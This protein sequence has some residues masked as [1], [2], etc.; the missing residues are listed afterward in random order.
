MKNNTAALTYSNP[1]MEAIIPDWPSG[2][3]L[4][5]ATFRIEVNSQGERATRTTVFWFV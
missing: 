4:M 2:S 1:R 3:H 5:T